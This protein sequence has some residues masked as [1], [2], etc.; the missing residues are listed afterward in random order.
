MSQVT[1][2]VLDTAAGRP[3]GGVPVSLE[4][5]DGVLATATTDRTAGSGSSG[6]D[7]SPPAPTGSASTPRPT[8]ARGRRS[9][10]R[11]S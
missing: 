1:T 11:W 5:A 10:R 6:P 4:G 2:H 8:S 7:G 9:S 3:A